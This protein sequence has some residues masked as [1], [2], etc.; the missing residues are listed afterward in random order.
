M[1]VIV[2]MHDTDTTLSF[3]SDDIN[4]DERE[5][6]YLKLIETTETVDNIFGSNG[7]LTNGLNEWFSDEGYYNGDI[8][9]YEGKSNSRATSIVTSIVKGDEGTSYSYRWSGYYSKCK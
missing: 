6:Y 1:I 4:V 5:I 9:W 8:T 2:N 3:D 7:V